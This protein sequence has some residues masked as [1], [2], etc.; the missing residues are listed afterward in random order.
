MEG[1]LIIGKVLFA[2][3]GLPAIIDVQEETFDEFQ[4]P[5]ELGEMKTINV[6]EL[7]I[8]KDSIVIKTELTDGF[9][10]VHPEDSVYE[11]V[12]DVDTYN[13][14]CNERLE[15]LLCQESV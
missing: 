1:K 11:I 8:R 9:R 2:R 12:P 10:V 5:T 13:K 6:K 3:V 4:S 7:L 15:F 14:V